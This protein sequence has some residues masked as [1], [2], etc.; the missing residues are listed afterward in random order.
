MTVHHEYENPVSYRADH[1]HKNEVA[2]FL[3][4]PAR[5][6]VDQTFKYQSPGATLAGDLL[7]QGDSSLFLLTA[8]EWVSK[9]FEMTELTAD[10]LV[11]EAELGNTS[12][13]ATWSHPGSDW[14]GPD[15]QIVSSLFCKSWE[16]PG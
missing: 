7:N 13:D 6:G 16:H 15:G 3:D 9:L 10:K 11:P 8:P 12:F 14:V 5:S 2:V 1:P 4:T